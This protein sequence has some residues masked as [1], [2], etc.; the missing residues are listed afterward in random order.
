[1]LVGDAHGRRSRRRRP[2]STVARS[3][4]SPSSGATDSGNRMRA[5]T[6]PAPESNHPGTGLLAVRDRDVGELEI[7]HPVEVE[8]AHRL[9]QVAPALQVPLAVGDEHLDGVDGAGRGRGIRRLVGERDRH[10]GAAAPRRPRSR[11]ASTGPGREDHLGRRAG[12]AAGE[13]GEQAGEQLGV[14]DARDRAG[15]LQS[16]EQRRRLARGQLRRAL[17]PDR[18]GDDDDVALVE[19]IPVDVEQVVRPS[20]SSRRRREGRSP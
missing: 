2:S 4:Y 20:A 11:T 7:A 5:T 15:Q 8:R 12:G 9:A 13:L 6:S 19:Q 10:T 16:G 14:A 18:V 3:R 1:M 17:Q